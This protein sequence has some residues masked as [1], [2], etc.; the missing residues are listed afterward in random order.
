MISGPAVGSKPSA[1]Q[2]IRNITNTG[3]SA[4][5]GWSLAWTWPDNQQVTSAWNA[6]VAQTGTHVTATNLSYN[7]TIAAGTST[8]FGFQ[9]AYTGTNTPPGQ[10]TLNGSSCS[11]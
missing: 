8:N 1:D 11:S 10:F 7:A 2:V 3:A 5:N 4:L 9:A 6:A